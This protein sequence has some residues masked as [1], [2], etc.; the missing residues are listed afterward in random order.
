MP[1]HFRHNRVPPWRAFPE[2]STAGSM[3]MRRGQGLRQVAAIVV[4]LGLAVAGP[5]GARA[6]DQTMVGEAEGALKDLSKLLD[7][8]SKAL[9]EGEKFAAS[10]LA[11][12][13]R[14]ARQRAEPTAQP[15]PAAIKTDLAPFFSAT[16]WLLDK[17]RWVTSE[18]IGGVSDLVMLNPDV[19]AITLDDV[20]VFRDKAD[21]ETNLVLWSHEL[22]HV[23][24]Y[25]TLGVDGFARDY[26]KSG[27]TE[28]EDEAETFSKQV[29]QKLAGRKPKVTSDVAES[30]QSS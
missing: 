14:D 6:D 27:G 20:I 25:Q 3:T 19:S 24:Q 13:I 26:L 9:P 11:Q 10:S 8:L 15:M 17:V 23:L 30:T 29:E 4:G 18:Q 28:F 21:G 16:P 1:A 12:A 5:I 22:V 7:T 2:G